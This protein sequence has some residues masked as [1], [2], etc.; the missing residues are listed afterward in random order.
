MVFLVISSVKLKP[1]TW[2]EYRG[3]NGEEMTQAMKNVKG[4]VIRYIVRGTEDPSEV[5]SLSFWDNKE[6]WLE[7]FGSELREEIIRPADHLLTGELWLRYYDI[8]LSSP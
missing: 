6:S 7:W 8:E 1:G 5:V 4:L 2:D 3:I